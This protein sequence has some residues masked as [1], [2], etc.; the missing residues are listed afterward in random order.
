M[1]T[2]LVRSKLKRGEPSV[3]T[4]LTLPDPIAAR[5][6]ARTGFDWLTVELEHAPVTIET[7]TQSFAVIAGNGTVPLARPPWNTAENIK[8]VLDNGAW[9]VV[10]PMVNSR[11]EA[12]AAVDAARYKPLG[13]RSVGG[14]LH[15][16]S[17]DTDPATYYER[18]NDEILVVAMIEHVQAVE[19]ADAILSVPG[20]D[21]F[22]IGPNDLTKSMG[23][24]PV[25]ESDDAEFV[26]ALEHL[27]QLGKKHGVASGIHVAD[28]AAA[29]RRIAEGF[30]MIAIASE[31][32]LMLAKAQEAVRALGL[33][34]A[35]PAVA[36]Y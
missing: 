33:G 28:A 34:T 12:E 35:R 16:A 30:Q 20:L 23:R 11:A 2:N 26:G 32:G 25:F 9:G 17:F 27:R 36:K 8:R 4:W 3:G 15:A 19:N 1:K 5:L 10:L 7:A 13:N 6:M 14:Q 22:F 21:A 18:A 31:A 29:Q 24:K